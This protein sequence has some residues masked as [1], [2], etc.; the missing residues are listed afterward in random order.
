MAKDSIWDFNDQARKKHLAREGLERA[1]RGLGEVSKAIQQAAGAGHLA[2]GAGPCYSKLPK[3][4]RNLP[5]LPRGLSAGAGKMERPLHSER[6][7]PPDQ[8]LG[9][10]D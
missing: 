3:L 8:A 7:R 6:P 2:A 4:G 5:R 9:A 10:G 1:W